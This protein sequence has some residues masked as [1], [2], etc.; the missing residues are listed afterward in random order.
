MTRND[1][2]KYSINT[3]ARFNENLWAHFFVCSHVNCSSD[4]CK[5]NIDNA[6]DY[7][8]N[9]LLICSNEFKR[10]VKNC[11]KKVV[12]GWNDR[13]KSLHFRARGAFLRW[14]SAG[15]P[16][17]GDYLDEMKLTRAQFKIAL[18]EC[19]EDENEI[20]N[21]KFRQSFRASNKADFWREIKAQSNEVVIK[22]LDNTIGDENIAEVFK[23]KYKVV[24]N[25]LNSNSLPKNYYETI[26]SS[27]AHAGLEMES[28]SEDDILHAIKRLNPGSSLDN[29]HSS[30]LKEASPSLIVFLKH[31]YNHILKHSYVPEK[32]LQG[33]IKPRIK[34]KFGPRDKSS[35]YRPVMTSSV[36]LKTLELCV[37]PKLMKHIK[38]D[39]A[40]F[41]FRKNTSTIMAI[42]LLKET[43]GSYTSNGNSVFCAFLD[44][45]SAFDKVNHKKLIMKLMESGVPSCLARFVEGLYS[46][47]SAHVLV[48]SS[49]S[50]SF[51]IKNGVRQGAILSPLL[52]NF[53]INSII[54]KI[55][56][57]NIGC[58][59]GYDMC[60]VFA[61]ADDVALVAPSHSALQLLLNEFQ[62]GI[63]ELDLTLN[64]NKSEAT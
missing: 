63:A 23:E 61:Y 25:D 22:K 6:S 64:I 5:S 2:L 33:R 10:K 21:E 27:K 1:R 54:E 26:S 62:K 52:F 7:L 14:R 17:S 35:N 53:Y 46:K 57:T 24:L 18:K 34:N 13:C 30:H 3:A 56:K 8:T 11:K 37:E 19:R 32:L 47:Q 20:R 36:V 40:Q 43:I 28:F 12:P 4:T 49:I 48:S 44:L 60:N 50:G 42:H 51:S 39:R 16:C 45:K 31:F 55:R 9:S 58:R 29:I 38:L 59:L 15:N 41:G